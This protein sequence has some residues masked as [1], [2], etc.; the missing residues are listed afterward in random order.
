MAGMSDF[1]E[2]AFMGHLF[3]DSTWA[4]PSALWVSLH[5]GTLNDDGTGTEVSG[6]SYARVQR[7]PGLA[8]WSFSGAT[9]IATNLA[10]I[11]FPAPTAN[12]GLIIWSGLWDASSGGNLVARAQLGTGKTVNNGDAAPRFPIGTLIYTAA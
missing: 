8:N 11:L 2:A 4:K 7:N 9:G 6:G 3:G 5:T 1:L 10:E 12:W